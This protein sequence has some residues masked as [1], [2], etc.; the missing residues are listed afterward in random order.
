M[1]T[2]KVDTETAALVAV[3]VRLLRAQGD[4]SVTAAKLIR[5][6]VADK[7]PEATRLVMEKKDDN[8]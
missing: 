1:T 5:G 3:V 8:Q 7:Y 2:I 6:M 4:K